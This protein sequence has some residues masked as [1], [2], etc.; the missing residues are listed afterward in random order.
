MRS[1]WSNSK[2][3]SKNGQ[4]SVLDSWENNIWSISWSN[5][6]VIEELANL[7]LHPVRLIL[8][9][10]V[11][12]YEQIW[13]SS[14]YFANRDYVRYYV[15]NKTSFQQHGEL[16]IPDNATRMKSPRVSLT[17]FKK[18]FLSSLLRG[19]LKG[20]MDVRFKTLTAYCPTALWID[21]EILCSFQMVHKLK[22]RS[23]IKE[24]NCA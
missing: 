18:L 1:R 21:V 13:N 12:Y 14:V 4:E 22:E 17:K 9:C 6:I 15:C 16:R 23:E 10:F 8:D 24:R 19:T 3:R 2:K 5:W 20:H 11:N 7:R